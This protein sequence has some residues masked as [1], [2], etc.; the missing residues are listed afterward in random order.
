[1]GYDLVDGI[2]GQLVE[3]EV[4]A[5]ISALM[6]MHMVEFGRGTAVYEM[7]LRPELGNPM[8]M[9]QGGAACVIAD[10]AMAM[11]TTTTLDDEQFTSSAVTTVD[12]FARYLRPVPCTEGTLRAEAQVVRSGSRV[13]W[14]ECDLFANEKLIGKFTGTGIKVGFKSENIVKV[15][16]DHQHHGH[17]NG[18]G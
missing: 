18:Q 2:M 1:M 17:G 9:L 10:V 14:A 11:A 8:G 15:E 3:G 7:P 6:D 4:R 16:G 5:P 13:V 12:L